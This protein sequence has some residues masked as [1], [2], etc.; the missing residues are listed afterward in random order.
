MIPKRIL[1]Y[2][3]K[4]KGDDVLIEG[5]ITCCN[6]QDFD[7]YT[8]GDFNNSFLK[9]HICLVGDKIALNVKCNKC[10]RD[11]LIF[12]SKYDGYDNIYGSAIDKYNYDYEMNFVQF[13]CSRC[14][15]ESF[16]IKIKYEYAGFD[17]IERNERSSN[18]FTWIWV[19]LECN[20]CHARYKNFI[21]YETS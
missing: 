15:S 12:N 14:S 4:V 3:D 2:F 13:K 7:I 8:H 17:E 10:K 5:R 18:A 20:Q 21:D 6:S 11:I 19:T 9:S 1:P 16:N